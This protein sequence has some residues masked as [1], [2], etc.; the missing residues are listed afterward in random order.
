MES[1]APTK[2]QVGSRDPPWDMTATRV[3]VNTWTSKNKAPTQ[4]DSE[5]GINLTTSPGGY[6]PLPRPSRGVAREAHLP[7]L[8]TGTQRLALMYLTA[9]FSASR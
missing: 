9:S 6:H 1:K 4:K 5:Q 3:L 2:Q 7:S 8:S